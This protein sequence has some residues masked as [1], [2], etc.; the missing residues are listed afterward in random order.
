MRRKT[1]LGVW[2]E[3]CSFLGPGQSCLLKCP[4]NDVLC[5]AE[6]ALLRLLSSLLRFIKL[7]MQLQKQLRY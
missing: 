7:R 2:L 6:A 3:V 4:R 5:C 1:S